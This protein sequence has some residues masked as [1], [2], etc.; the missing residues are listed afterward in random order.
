MSNI[1]FIAMLAAMLAALATM[2]IGIIVMGKGGEAN[3]KYG[4]KLMR[5]RVYLQ[6]LALALFALAVLSSQ[7]GA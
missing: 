4:H 5:A 6:G 2:A 1:L 7:S 3:Q